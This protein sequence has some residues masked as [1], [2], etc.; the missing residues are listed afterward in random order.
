MP[1][2][3]D[4]EM[5]ETTPDGRA[6]AAMEQLMPSINEEAAMVDDAVA[7][8]TPTGRYTGKRLNAA[9]VVI[10]KLFKLVGI[11]DV[12]MDPSYTDVEG[13]L[14][15]AIVKAFAGIREALDAF[16]AAFPEEQDGEMY[17]VSALVTDADIAMVTAMLDQLMK[18]KVFQRFLREEEPTVSIVDRDW[19]TQAHKRAYE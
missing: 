18:N 9:S 13:P 3:T 16:F 4:E 6:E 14:P 2:V 17:D 8:M 7:A 10:N 15:V 19:E 1:M 11:E 12:E 5:I